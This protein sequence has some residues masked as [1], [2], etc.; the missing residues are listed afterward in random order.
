MID[1]D[2]I[3]TEMVGLQ[4]MPPDQ[5]LGCTQRPIQ[6][7][8][9]DTCQRLSAREPT[10]H[11]NDQQ[12]APTTGHDI[13]LTTATDPVA[14]GDSPA[15][16]PQMPTGPG[17]GSKTLSED[18]VDVHGHTVYPNREKPARESPSSS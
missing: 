17:F 14:G 13:E 3:E 9:I 6:L 15:A 1:P 11:F 8:A 10:P 2:E 16:P 4:I 5:G 12:G 7:I 18:R